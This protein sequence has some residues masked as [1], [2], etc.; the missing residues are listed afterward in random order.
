[1]RTPAWQVVSDRR[2]ATQRPLYRVIEPIVDAQL[3][4]AA[5]LG[6]AP[7][8]SMVGT[9]PHATGMTDSTSTTLEKMQQSVRSKLWASSL[10]LRVLSQRTTSSSSARP[11][12]PVPVLSAARLDA[13]SR[14]PG[15]G[16]RIRLVYDSS[17]TVGRI[18]Y[19]MV[20]GRRPGTLSQVA[21]WEGSDS[22][23]WAAV[24]SM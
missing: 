5:L 7:S 8:T 19:V 2:G 6:A 21:D 4:V 24:W 3:Q 16:H 14:R 10:L 12:A 17:L 20:Q 18:S 13:R 23:L 15:G 22:S 9:Y 11:T 1:M